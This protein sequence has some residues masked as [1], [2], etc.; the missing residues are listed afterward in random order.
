[1]HHKYAKDGLVVVSVA[2][3]DLKE[4]PGA[5][6]RV[7]KFLKAQRATF[8]NLLLDEPF[9]FWSERLHFVAPPCQFVFSRQGKWTKFEGAIKH[10]E[11]EKLV[12]ELLREK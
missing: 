9:E 4:D 2:L 6:D 5:K 3:D 12:V 10:E 11:V 8:T 7:L 1:M